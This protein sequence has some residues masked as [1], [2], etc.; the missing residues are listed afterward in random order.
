MFKKLGAERTGRDDRQLA[1][2]LAFI[3]G[4]VNSVGFIVIGSFT[5]H[6]TG[7]VGRVADQ[8]ARGNASVAGLAAMTVVAFFLGAI[9]ASMLIESQVLRNMS[10]TSAALLFME[11]ILVAS[12][13]AS[14]SRHPSSS[15]CI[16]GVHAILLSFAMGIQNSL[17]TR[18]S[19]AVVRTTHLTGVVTDLGIEVAR[20]FRYW[21]FRIGEG[22]GMRLT[23]TSTPATLPLVAKT[24]LLATIFFAFVIGSACGAL[25]GVRYGSESL[26]PIVLLLVAGA[27]YALIS[28]RSIVP[29]ER[30]NRRGE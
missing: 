27:I 18:L 22:R 3:A 8:A 24:A 15:L 29:I 7:N 10:R 21:R 1:G 14:T 28:G 19:G 17:V 30:A 4:T 13:I 23:L 9:T 16:S 20:W 5:S 11:A 2:Y 6:V 25:M 12:F 26:L